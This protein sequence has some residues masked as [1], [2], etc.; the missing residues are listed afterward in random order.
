MLKI[1]KGF[2]C[3]SEEGKLGLV[4][5]ENRVKTKTYGTVYKGINLQEPNFGKVWTSRNPHIVGLFDVN[6]G[7]L[8]FPGKVRPVI[9]PNSTVIKILHPTEYGIKSS[10]EEE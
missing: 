6:T 5:S 9:L 3:Y 10:E 1:T 2:I 8:K 7:N 4:T